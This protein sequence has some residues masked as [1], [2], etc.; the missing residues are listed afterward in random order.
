MGQLGVPLPFFFRLLTIVSQ[1]YSTWTRCELVSTSAADATRQRGQQGCDGRGL[2]GASITH[3]FIS[4]V[5][6]TNYC[7]PMLQHLNAT[8]MG[9]HE[10]TRRKSDRVRQKRTT[11]SPVTFLLFCFVFVTNYS[12][13]TP[14]RREQTGSD[15]EGGRDATEEGLTGCVRR[16]FRFCY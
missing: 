15:D 5:F 3:F 8:R 4:F 7:I 14:M 6:V 1:C 13:P 2:Q 9:K 10:C 16:P 12:I 11:G